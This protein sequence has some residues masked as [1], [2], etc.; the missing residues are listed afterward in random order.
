[1]TNYI[2]FN[3]SIFHATIISIIMVAYIDTI[4][5][6]AAVS[7]CIILFTSLWNHGTRSIMAQLIDRCVCLFTSGIIMFY[8]LISPIYLGFEMCMMM[9]F[10]GT[11]IPLSKF[12]SETNR[13]CMHLVAHFIATLCVIWFIILYEPSNN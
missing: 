1:M 7:I 12:C 4:P 10:A 3:S 9:I 2:L 5:L 13:T 11:L 8:A 6:V